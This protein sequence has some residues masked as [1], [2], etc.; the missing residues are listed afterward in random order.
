VAQTDF[1]DALEK[2]QPI[3]AVCPAGLLVQLPQINQPALSP[4]EP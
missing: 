2:R 3:T 1:F 4:C